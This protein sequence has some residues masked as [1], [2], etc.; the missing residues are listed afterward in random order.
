[1]FGH[2]EYVLSKYGN[3]D[4]TG[5]VNDW[6]N[7]PIPNYRIGCARDQL[8]I[9]HFI[10]TLGCPGVLSNG[11]NLQGFGP[12]PF[13]FSVICYVKLSTLSIERKK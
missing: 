4:F 5:G 3:M 10:L 8:I 6:T 12:I 13:I 1:V 2:A 11:H 9:C 7:D